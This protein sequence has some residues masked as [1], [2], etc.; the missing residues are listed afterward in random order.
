MSQDPQDLPRQSYKELYKEG[1]G[2]AG[3][4]RDGRTTSQSGPERH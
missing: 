1:E 3:R 4:E 2:E